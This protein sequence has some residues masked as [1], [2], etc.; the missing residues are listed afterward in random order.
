[1]MSLNPVR[2]LNREA[3][4]EKA[5][6]ARL[7]L[8]VGAIA[9]GELVKST[10]GPKGMDKILVAHGRSAGQVEVTNDGATILKSIGVDNPAAKILVNMSKV[11]DDEVGDGTTSVT[12]FAS[13]LLK[14]AEKLIEQKIHPQTIIEGWRVAQDVA[15]NALQNATSDN[16][17]DSERFRE[18]LMN[19]ARTTLS[20]KILSQHKE[21][22]SKLAVD[23]VLSP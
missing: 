3:E 14:E 18:D 11:Q 10:L 17:A 22:F 21:H 4:E 8:F 20:S 15:K 16:S 23:A 13:E 6:I 19:I 9:I 1:M 7:S 12:V 5:E 2:V